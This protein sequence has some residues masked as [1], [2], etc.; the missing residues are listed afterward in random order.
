MFGAAA[1]VVLYGCTIAREEFARRYERD[2]PDY[3]YILAQVS[4]DQHPRMLDLGR[5]NGGDWQ[6]LCAIGSYKNATRLI[7]EEAD[8]RQVKLEGIVAPPGKSPDLVFLD[9]PES[10][11]AFVDASGNGRI[12]LFGGF[13][14]VA[15]QHTSQ[16]FGPETRQIDLPRRRG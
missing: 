6:F 15:E 5:I 16:C 11:I 9:D 4:A 13:Q 12:V 1:G 3:R 14:H 8:R 10:A 2:N 7:R